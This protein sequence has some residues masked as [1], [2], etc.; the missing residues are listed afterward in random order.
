MRPVGGP[1]GAALAGTLPTGTVTF[2]FTDVEGST[3]RW[4]QRKDAMAAAIER[5]D[6]LLQRAVENHGGYL[7]KRTGDGMCAAFSLASDALQS[8]LEAQHALAQEDFT[9][10]DGLR[11]RM[12]LHTGEAQERNGDYFGQAV[13][14]T[15]RLLAVGHGGQILASGLTAALLK[16][17][18]SAAGFIDLGTHRLKDL[19]EPEHVFQLSGEIAQRE[20]PPLRSLDALPN[21]LPLQ[22]TSF[23]GREDE[24]AALTA[25]L[26]TTRLI[27]LAGTGGVGKTRFAI[28]IGGDVADDYSDGVWFVE[29]AAITDPELVPA[30]VASALNIRDSQHR[31]VAESIVTSLGTKRALLILDNCEQVIEAAA[32]LAGTIL[33]TCPNARIIAT[34]RQALGITGEWIHRVPSLSL[35]TSTR[36][37][38]ARDAVRY[39]AIALFV[40]RATASNDQFSLTDENAK[41]VAEICRRLDGIALAIELAATRV[42][43]F[44]AR[45]LNA[46]LK[47]RFD[48]LTGGNR[49]ELPRHQTMR[50]LIDWS[51]DLLDAAEKTFFRRAAIFAGGFSMEAATFACGE[52]LGDSAVLDLTVSLVEKSLLNAET[53]SGT[54][55]YR[56]LESTRAYG[57]D[58]LNDSSERSTIAR[59]HAEFYNAVAS[60]AD[61]AFYT[62][63]QKEWF[64]QV[65][66]EIDNMRG[67]LLWSLFEKCDPVVGAGLAGAL[68]RFWYEV[69]QVSEG[70]QWIDRALELLSEVQFP[71]IAA[72]VWLARAVLTEG[73]ESCRAAEKA[74]QLYEALGDRRGLGFAL[75]EHG[76]A[77]RQVGNLTQ[78]EAE[79]S[80]AAA[81]L[82]EVQEAGGFAIALNTLGSI[83]A[84]RGEFGPAR[85]NY[86]RALEAARV[87]NAE[88][89][90]MM[91]YL[92]LAD[93]E[94][95]CGNFDVAIQDAT[96]ALRLAEGNKSSRLPANLHVNLAAYQIAAGRLPEAAKDAR[97]ALSM[98]RDIQNSYQIA[99]AVQHLA[100]IAAL[101]S[102][103]ERAALLIGFVDAYFAKNGLERQPTEAG[104]RVR[105]ETL[106]KECGTPESH[107]TQMRRGAALTEQA[108]IAAALE[109]TE[110]P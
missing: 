104:G 38:T 7:F 98:L 109:V 37:L 46:H 53:G 94:Y 108:A 52:T 20:F 89:A 86:E 77:L 11:V 50:A 29:L 64:A 90:I 99:I 1:S 30:V 14:R 91:S 23:I 88:F 35:P 58:K 2:L 92:H 101:G 56:F 68:G 82:N 93:L 71:H 75:R 9:A 42:K 44:T 65:R 47:E 87:H 12:A 6:A 26:Q 110:A 78:A 105:I 17:Q 80:R 107:V 63:P 34:S 85:K 45:Q 27:T 33:Q 57:L 70:K 62:V 81:L 59:K 24:L 3:R 95:Q 39:G 61:D 100:L 22:L 21:N 41:D 40:E 36:G 48:L 84:F 66:R 103:V 79:L 67:A 72:R 10:I 76:L 31:T 69:G 74:C 97:E 19:T 102:D 43:V 49:M 96:E 51:Y 73:L 55:R 60:R 83:F 54:M 16:S 106:L 13:N 32:K 28:Q 5:H 4:E 15:A 25:R 8:A 18:T